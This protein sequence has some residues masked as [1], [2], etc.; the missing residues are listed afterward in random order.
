[1]QLTRTMSPQI[2]AMDEITDERDALSLLAAAGCGTALLASVHAAG[3]EDLRR[4][5]ALRRLL[6]AGVFEKRVV[7]ARLGAQRR[8][9][10]AAL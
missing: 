10:A 7:I 2:V 3:V 1:M 5:P 6:A 4:R 8:Y 9:E